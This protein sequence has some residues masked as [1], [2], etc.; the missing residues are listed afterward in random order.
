M[1]LVAMCFHL[2]WFRYPPF[3][4]SVSKAV[5]HWEKD[6]LESLP[7]KWSRSQCVPNSTDFQVTNR[8]AI[9]FAC[10]TTVL[11]T[12]NLLKKERE[13]ILSSMAMAC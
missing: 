4:F 12:C 7:S 5:C 6:K 9:S 11:E 1:L 3:V 10:E 8:V 13:W 2:N